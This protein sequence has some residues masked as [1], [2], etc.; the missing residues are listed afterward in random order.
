[1]QHSKE[2]RQLPRVQMVLEGAR[3]RRGE[4]ARGRGGKGAWGWGGEEGMDGF[5]VKVSCGVGQT[6]PNDYNPNDNNVV[7]FQL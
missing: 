7:C 4:G 5:V 2:G 3:G 1:L 6:I